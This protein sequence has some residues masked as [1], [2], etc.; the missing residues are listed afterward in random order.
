M[1]SNYHYPFSDKIIINM[2]PADIKKEGSGF[3]LPIA[4]GI[5]LKTASLESIFTL[6]LALPMYRLFVYLFA[7]E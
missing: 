7:H 3:D 2:A 6:L 1:N 4:M 5:F